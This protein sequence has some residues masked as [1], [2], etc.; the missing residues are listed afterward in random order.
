MG[1]RIDLRNIFCGTWG[2][3]GSLV[4][5]LVLVIGFS[6]SEAN[7]GPSAAK[8]KELKGHPFY[9]YNLII[10]IDIAPAGKSLHAQRVR[11]HRYDPETKSV[12]FIGRWAASTGAGT[13]KANEK[14]RIAQRK[15]HPG[16]YNIEFLEI[17]A[18]SES[19]NGP[20]PYALYW[21]Y[22]QG[23][24]IHATEEYNY[25]KLGRPAS[26]GCTRLTLSN[27]TEL[28]ATV[29][30]MGKDYTYKLDRQTG[31]PVLNGSGNPVV[32]YSYQA[33]VLI[34]NYGVKEPTR[35][36]F[37][38][39]DEVFATNRSY[40]GFMS[41]PEVLQPYTPVDENDSD[42]LTKDKSDPFKQSSLQYSGPQGGSDP[43]ALEDVLLGGGQHA[44]N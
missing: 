6:T 41:P 36:G 15:T 37:R 5:A 24:A 1:R 43:I 8:L 30:M 22:N 2:A 27:A 34:E 23:F 17:D 10:Q 32:Q 3:V 44:N 39:R 38:D 25:F 33:M 4:L 7:A 16:Y 21:N 40:E 26:A 31:K 18:Y 11:V 14:G 35:F 19:W 9:G 42:F 13:P 29:E 28:Y 12:E 20:M